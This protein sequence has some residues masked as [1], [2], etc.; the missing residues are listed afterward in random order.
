MFPKVFAHFA[1]R[2]FVFLVIIGTFEEH[3]ALRLKPLAEG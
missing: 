1:E 2:E 3:Q